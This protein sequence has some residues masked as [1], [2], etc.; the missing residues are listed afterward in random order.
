MLLVLLFMF[1]RQMEL[2]TFY[3]FNFSTIMHWGTLALRKR[4]VPWLNDPLG[5]G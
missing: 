4:F 3:S 1:A 5:K 2:V